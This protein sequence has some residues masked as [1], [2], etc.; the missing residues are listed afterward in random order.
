MYL[1]ANFTAMPCGY[2]VRVSPVDL[3]VVNVFDTRH[4]VSSSQLFESDFVQAEEH[5][6]L[7]PISF[8]DIKRSR[9]CSANPIQS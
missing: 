6:F 2:F 8:L 7:S 5:G 4:G 1:E 9:S 3:R